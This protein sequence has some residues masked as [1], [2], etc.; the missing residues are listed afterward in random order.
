MAKLPAFY[1]AKRIGTL[2]YPD[3]ARI[4]AEA[5]REGLKPVAEDELGVQL[6]LIDMQVSFCHERGSLHVPGATEDVRRV[7]EFIYRNAER[8]SQI[9]C[10]LD[11]H[12]PFQIFHALW[13]IG[14]DGKHPPPF[15][16]ITAA[17]VDA[18]RWRP[19]RDEEW[20]RAYVHRLEDE[21]KKQLT[22]WPYHAQIGSIG[23][24]LDPE[25]W[26]A[27]FWHS[28][29]R[30]SQPTWWRKGSIPRTEH[31]SILRPEIHVPGDPRGGLNSDFVDMI[32]E[33]DYVVI[34][35]E[36]AS[37]CV[38]ESVADMIEVF[39]HM[40]EKLERIFILRDCM[41]PVRHPTIDFGEVS[42]RQ[43]AVY[44]KQGP[45]FIDSTD[46]FPF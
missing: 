7:I 43:F 3:V 36:A 39:R 16:I 32:D 28:V 19:L 14:A 5:E 44:E 37:H 26:S 30:Q 8:I 11:S 12:Y 35:G 15:T 6:L 42:R 10:T 1:D 45:R 41:S 20:S 27:I 38:L 4:A 21:A 31:Y 17:D 2:F 18:G 29:A 40:P 25:L 34:A 22:I 13:W 33:Y 24:S 9:T 46:P 23:H